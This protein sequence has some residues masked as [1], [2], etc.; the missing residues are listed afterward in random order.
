MAD[1]I[2]QGVQTEVNHGGYE[3]GDAN[4]R[5]IFISIGVIF[6]LIF[7]TML[8]V[9]GMTYA[10]NKR[11]DSHDLPMS[12]VYEKPIPPE[13]R[14]LPSRAAGDGD[15]YDKYPWELGAE[16][17][18]AQMKAAT[19]PYYMDRASGRVSIPTNQAI[20]L[21]AAQGLPSRQPQ[22]KDEPNM[23]EDIA[24]QN[25]KSPQAAA[26]ADLDGSMVPDTTGGRAMSDLHIQAPSLGDEPQNEDTTATEPSSNNASGTSA[27]TT[28]RTPPDQANAAGAT[29]SS[30]TPST[31]AS[32]ASPTSASA[33]NASRATSASPRVPAPNVAP[34]GTQ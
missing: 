33:A 30:M 1:M 4:I 34:M 13:P 22:G 12:A 26:D 19:T 25:G 7:A 11:E 28:S 16:E 24:G 9:A 27:P 18:D 2:P 6:S 23:G 3:R 14:L 5:S 32:S 31:S 10:L 29:N 21:V 15:P 8:V 20:D 17:K